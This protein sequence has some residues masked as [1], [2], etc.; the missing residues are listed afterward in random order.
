MNDVIVVEGLHD[1]IKIKSVYPDAFCV[2]TNGSEISDE[3][4]RYI[5]KLSENHNIIIFTDPDSPGEKIRSEVLRV[6]PNAKNAFIHKKDAISGNKKKVGVEHATKEMIRLSLDGIYNKE[7]NVSS[8]ITNNDLFEIGLNGYD[9]SSIYRDR[10]S[11]ILNIG[12][13]N[14]KSFLKRVNQIGLTLDELKE[15]LCQVKL[16]QKKK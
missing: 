15:L 16:E 5:K 4:L 2:I 7:V 3:T 11:D 9:N 8:N 6:V 10:I 12:K 13:P 1:E 14:S